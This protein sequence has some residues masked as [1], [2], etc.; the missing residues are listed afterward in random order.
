MKFDTILEYQDLDRELLSVENE[1]AKSPERAAFVNAKAKLEAATAAVGKLSHEA[2][3]LLAG[4]GRLSSRAEELKAKLDEFDGILEGVA[5]VNEADYYIRQ[6][7]SISEEIA[8]LEKDASKD[9]ERI[10]A[11]ASEYK[12]TWEVGR[13]ASDAY[14]EA[15]AAFNAFASKI[16]PR[17][18]ELK[19]GLA[20]LEKNV[21][22]EFMTAYKSL[23]AAKKTPAF[24]A[25]KPESGTCGRCFMEVSGATRSKLK[26]PGDHAECPNCRRILYIPEE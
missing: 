24:V 21:P 8:S 22:E 16:Q 20:K 4:Y 3:E 17:I 12:K 13:K 2:A 1:V 5:D 14:K 11:I 15:H 9:G 23:R 10:D 6:I 7:A 19:E 18:T 26:N 25:Y